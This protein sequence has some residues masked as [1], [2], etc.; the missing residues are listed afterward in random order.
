MSYELNCRTRV[1]PKITTRALLRTAK[2][3]VKDELDVPNTEAVLAVFYRLCIEMDRVQD[4]SCAEG[5]DSSENS[6]H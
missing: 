2:S 3:I 4:H 6:I 1:T 5:L